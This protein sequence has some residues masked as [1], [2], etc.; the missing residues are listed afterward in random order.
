MFWTSSL[1]FFIKENW[2]WTKTRHHAESNSNILLTRNLPIDSGIRQWSHRFMI[3]LHCL[4]AKSNNRTPGQF[5]CDMTWFYFCFDF[6]RSHARCAFCSIV[7]W[8]EWGVCLKLDVQG[9]GGGTILD[10]DGQETWGSWKLDNSRER[11]MFIVSYPDLFWP[12]VCS[13][14]HITF[15]IIPNLSVIFYF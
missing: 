14:K 9:Q 1:Y 10:V 4:W 2:I 6:V 3:P 5:E 12:S 13:L 15:L 11:H 8:R 7:C